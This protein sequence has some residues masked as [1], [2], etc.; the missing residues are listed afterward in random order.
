MTI[1]MIHVY[2]SPPNGFWPLLIS[3]WLYG[4]LAVE[5]IT[6]EKN[7]A[8]FF[9]KLFLHSCSYFFWCMDFICL[10]SDNNWS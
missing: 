9:R 6:H 10:G 4:W 2:D 5:K 8:P 7:I 1:L 3:I